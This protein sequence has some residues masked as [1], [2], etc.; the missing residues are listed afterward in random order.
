MLGLWWGALA[1][2]VPA[3]CFAGEASITVDETRGRYASGYL[4]GGS[5]TGLVIESIFGVELTLFDGIG[6]TSRLADFDPAARLRNLPYQGRL[7]TI[8]REGVENI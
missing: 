3:T 7:R 1:A 8:V 2:V 6:V 5:F 4:A